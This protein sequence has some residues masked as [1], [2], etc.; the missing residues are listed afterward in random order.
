M[1]DS[2]H[3]KPSGAHSKEIWI[4]LIGAAATVAVALITGFFGL[5]SSD[6]GAPAPAPAA[7]AAPSV[8]IEGPLAAPLGEQ[9]FFTIVSQNAVRAEWSAGGFGDGRSIEIQPLPPSHQIWIE[10]TDSTRIGDTFTLA[11]TVYG[12]DGQS[13][14]AQRQFQVTA[15][16]P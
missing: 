7:L 3:G 15:A 10:P 6:R 16:Q 12:A 14:T 13:A 2:S 4:A 5:L 9:T 8:A 11:V 1:S